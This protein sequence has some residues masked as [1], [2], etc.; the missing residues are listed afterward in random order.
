MN[1]PVIAIFQ[2]HSAQP[3]QSAVEQHLLALCRGRGLRVLLLPHLNHLAEHGSLWAA[4]AQAGDHLAVFSW[5]HPRPARWIL[6]RHRV[7]PHRF[8]AFN[9]A[10]LATSEA[11]TAALDTVCPPDAHI[12]TQSGEVVELHE[13]FSPRWYPVVD[14]SRCTHCLQCLQFCLFGV[15]ARSDDKRLIVQNPDQC[16]PG[17]PACSRICPHN[18]I[19]FPLYD[20]DPVIAGG[21]APAAAPP[22]AV[23][24]FADLDA[25][26]NEVDEMLQRRR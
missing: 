4:L 15:Y 22:V 19:M 18:A 5:L 1:R 20:K 6:H 3:H 10:D 9:L 14:E 21:D 13:P 16:K 17:C 2:S 7:T 23:S 11:R 12:Y 24:A 8:D 26:V 25:L